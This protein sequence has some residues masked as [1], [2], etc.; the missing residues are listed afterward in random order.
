[1]QKYKFP[2]KI[3][4]DNKVPKIQGHWALRKCTTRRVS[5][6]KGT[7][8]NSQQVQNAPFVVN[9][10]LGELK[11]LLIDSDSKVKRAFEFVSNLTS[12]LGSY[13]RLFKNLLHPNLSIYHTIFSTAKQLT[14]HHLPLFENAE[15]KKILAEPVDNDDIFNFNF[16]GLEVS[17]SFFLT[18]APVR[19]NLS[20]ALLCKIPPSISIFI[21]SLFFHLF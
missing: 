13:S 3:S 19:L 17:L 10:A 7:F 16:S 9:C 18:H 5:P 1:M 6:I 14:T 11:G 12:L 20:G 21:H 8:K 15:I 4:W 2:V